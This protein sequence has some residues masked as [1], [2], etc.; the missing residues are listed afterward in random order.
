MMHI[1]CKDKEYFSINALFN[2]FILR[3]LY[4]DMKESYCDEIDLYDT[5]HEAFRIILEYMYSGMVGKVDLQVS[6][7]WGMLN[8]KLHNN[9]C[10]I[11]NVS[12]YF[13]QSTFNF[14]D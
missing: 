8:V 4:G 10:S 13:I 14:G 1:V 6:Y 9:N 5:P 7:C 11:Y 12:T 2:S 3:L